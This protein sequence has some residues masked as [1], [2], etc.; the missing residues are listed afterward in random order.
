MKK[1][2]M[3]NSPDAVRD[4]QD[5]PAWYWKSGLHDAR[6]LSLDELTLT[7]DWK[8]PNP[9][10]NCLRIHLDADGAMFDSLVT[11]VLL[12]NYKLRV[13]D[14][15]DNEFGKTWWLW[16]DIERLP[17][18]RWHLA[19]DAVTS[20]GVEKRIVVDFRDAEV[21]RKQQ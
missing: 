1:K 21:E 18:G 16:D 20:K 15:A 14:I 11:T 9:R 10:C 13:M 4:G 5:M 2:P 7:F 19:V 6:I 12:Y 8:S 3:K 17:D